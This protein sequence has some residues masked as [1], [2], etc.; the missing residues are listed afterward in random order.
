MPDHHAVQAI[1]RGDYRFFVRKE[2]EVRQEANAPPIKSLV[3]VQTPPPVA[4]ELVERL[5]SLPGTRVLGPAPGGSLG[6]QLLLRVDDL[7][8]ILEPLGTMIA[9]SPQRTLVEVDPKDW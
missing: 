6:C 2:L 8:T 5:W 3:R 1:V 7:E 9:E 4:D